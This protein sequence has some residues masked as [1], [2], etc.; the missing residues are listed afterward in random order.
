MEAEEAVAH[1][2][3]W[4]SALLTQS[5]ACCP[6]HCEESKSGASLTSHEAFEL[7]SERKGKKKISKLEH[8]TVFLSRYAG[9]S[10]DLGPTIGSLLKC[11]VP[12]CLK[13]VSHLLSNSSIKKQTL[14]MGFLFPNFKCLHLV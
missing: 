14:R 9:K 10:A 1:R 6:R 5:S 13:W 12:V 8:C 2:C 7:A 4:C 11:V 3:S